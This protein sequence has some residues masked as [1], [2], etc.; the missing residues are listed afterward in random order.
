M[1]NDDSPVAVK[2]RTGNSMNMTI[3]SIPAFLSDHL[4]HLLQAA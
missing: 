2:T 1:Y 4:C 3:R